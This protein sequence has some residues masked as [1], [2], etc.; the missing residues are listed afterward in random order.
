MSERR[1]AVLA[2]W[3]W[4]K[5]LTERNGL[6]LKDLL[7]LG[8]Q[9]DPFAC[10]QPARQQVAAWFAALWLTS[11]IVGMHL[12]RFHY[13]LVSQST[14]VL[15][16]NGQPY[17]NTE[18]CWRALQAGFANARYLDMVDPTAFTER[19][20]AEAIIHTTSRETPQPAAFVTLIDSAWTLPTLNPRACV[21]LP[22]LTEAGGRLDVWADC[23]VRGYDYDPADQPYTC[24]VVIEKSTMN[25]VLGPLCAELG[26]DLIVGV[27]FSSIT[28]VIELLRRT[29]KPVLIFYLHDF[30]PAGRQM[31]VAFA[32]QLEFWRDRFA[33]G[34][35]IRL[36]S[37]LL[38]AAQ[39]QHYRLPRTPI[40]DSDKRK[41]S[42]EEI[43]GAGAVELDALEAV[44]PGELARLVRDAV[45]PS[46]D[47][48]LSRRLQQAQQDANDATETQWQAITADDRRRLADLQT[49]VETVTA[50]AR[51]QLAAAL[52][53]F[54]TELADLESRIHA[55]TQPLA[56]ALTADLAPLEAEL[57]D[58][59]Q[60]IHTA[61][62]TLVI[63][64]PDRP[65][66]AVQLPDESNVLYDSNRDYLTQTRHYLRHKWTPGDVAEV[67]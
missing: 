9:N 58:I 19:R 10:P 42:F 32:R 64:L 29:R 39:V 4:I 17:E 18:S 49:R 6:T 24:V 51:R 59:R 43:H 41:A 45:R 16:V 13:R 53:P 7:P 21:L 20:S 11:G 35:E 27:G 46:H 61:T 36:H 44:H 50:D 28:R 8:S 52:A 55:A 34:I 33:A 47:P 23:D 67:A 26:I 57:E 54:H 1:A 31:P 38:T 5:S 62:D 2:N 25:D 56:D 48:T 22:T 30:D 37:L 65:T 66:P 60:A 40:K 15:M 3:Q 63:D 14:P 12:R